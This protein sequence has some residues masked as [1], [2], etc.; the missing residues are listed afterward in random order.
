[1]V[2]GEKKEERKERRKKGRKKRRWNRNEG[3]KE[4]RITKKKKNNEVH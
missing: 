2:H 4:I 3:I 1:M